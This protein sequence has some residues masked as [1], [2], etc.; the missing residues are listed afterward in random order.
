M[1]HIV[2]SV[3]AR[4][5]D[6]PVDRRASRPWEGRLLWQ[7]GLLSY[8]GAGGSSAR[9]SHH[10]V[11]LAV[12]FDDPLE[13]TV[14]DLRTVVGAV[15]IPGS[16]PHAVETRGRRI[17]Y[18]LVEPHGVLGAALAT[19][20]KDLRGR[21]IAE[22]IPSLSEPAGDA[23]SLITHVG[24]LIGSLAPRPAHQDLSPAVLTALEYLD[25]SLSGRP[26]LEDAARAAHISPSRLTHIF[27]E[28]LGI[29]FRRFVV[30]LRLRRAAEYRWN[31]ST[32]TEAAVAA[33]FSDGAHLSRVCR[34]T[35]GVSPSALSEMRPA[36]ACW[37]I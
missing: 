5:P 24:R 8:V 2:V 11:Q 10:A 17:F 12:S 22:L 20:A 6:P 34:Q 9:H 28:Q 14:G 33:G 19:R 7:P 16:V 21:D 31:T 25:Y 3:Q 26:R 35:F 32:L 27:S 29:P 4:V 36:S 18:A 30:W 15:L 37:P 13:V 1:P 23:A